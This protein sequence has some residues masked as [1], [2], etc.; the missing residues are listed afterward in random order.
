MAFIGPRTAE[1]D[2]VREGAFLAHCLY[3]AFGDKRKLCLEAL[4]RYQWAPRAT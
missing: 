4:E 3:N 2:H 1:V